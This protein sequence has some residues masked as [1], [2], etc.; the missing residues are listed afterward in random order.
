MSVREIRGWTP[1]TAAAASAPTYVRGVINL[2]G[3]VLPI[4]DLVGAP[5][6]RQPPSPPC[7]TSSSSPSIGDRMVGLLVDAVSDILTATD[8]DDP[9]DAGRRL[10][11]R[12]D[13]SSSGILAHRRPH[14][15]PRS[16]STGSCPSR[17]PEAA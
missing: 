13:A 16:R 8:D 5:G 17:K 6:P 14:D 11:R 7:A 10:R 12:Q 3:A 1:A 2:R 4:V 15:Q 9:A